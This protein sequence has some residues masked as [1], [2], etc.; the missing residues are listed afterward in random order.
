MNGDDGLKERALQEEDEEDEK[1][2][3]GIAGSGRG[4]ISGVGENSHVGEMRG[5]KDGDVVGGDLQEQLDNSELC[6]RACSLDVGKGKFAR[7]KIRAK[8]LSGRAFSLDASRRGVR[9]GGGSG[10]GGDGGGFG[11]AGGGR[12]GGVSLSSPS[13]KCQSA[14]GGAAG[15]TELIA[16]T[17]EMAA[18]QKMP[19]R[20][21]KLISWKIKLSTKLSRRYA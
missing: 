3:N 1:P 2:S 4:Y 14:E 15:R 5:G 10:C 12:G 19:K 11:G 13:A 17:E 8:L 6:S 16:E 7:L 18:A 20:V 9:N 21:K